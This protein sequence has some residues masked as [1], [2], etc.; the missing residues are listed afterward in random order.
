MEGDDENEREEPEDERVAEPVEHQRPHR[1]VE[2][3][4]VAPVAGDEAADPVGVAYGKRP[5]VSEL[6]V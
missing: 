3:G 4:G 5:V 1:R 6:V 2:E